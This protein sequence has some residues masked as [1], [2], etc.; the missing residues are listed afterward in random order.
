VTDTR[1]IER[2]APTRMAYLHGLDVLRVV[3]SIAVVYVHTRDWFASGQRPWRLHEWLT[4]AVFEPLHVQSLLAAFAVSTFFLISGLVVTQ[5][6]LKERVA[7]FVARRS[8]RIL[9]AL[10]V[11]LLAVWI[12]AKAGLKPGVQGNGELD[13]PALLANMLLLNFFVPNT[14]ALDLVAWTLV[15]QI[16]FYA[17]VAATI[18]LAR[19]WPWLPPALSVAA[20][21]I[22]LSVVATE[23]SPALHTARTIITLVPVLFVGQLIALVRLRRLHPLAAFG[24]AALL[25]L[26]FVRADLTSEHTPAIPGYA[27]IVVWVTLLTIIA[28]RWRG[29]FASSPWI[30]AFAERTYAIFLV[31]VPVFY[32]TPQLL[33][34]AAGTPL[35][36][37][38]ALLG[39][40]ITAELLYRFVERPVA[41]WYRAWERSRAR[42]HGKGRE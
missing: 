15:V 14:P 3:A 21:S 32:V 39:V 28:T 34:T 5:A 25:M 17:F 24:Y 6:A 12:A 9:P 22:A 42:T 11:V 41:R 30:A 36:F 16:S 2:L 20:V 27:Q 10:W 1:P 37:V 31:H 7:Q 23:D 8:V 26:L 19:R 29:R 33:F 18:P 38:V 35:A 13:V 4:R 40:A